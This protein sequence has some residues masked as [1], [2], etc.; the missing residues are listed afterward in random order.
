M[1]RALIIVLLTIVVSLAC[2]QYLDAQNEQQVY[3]FCNQWSSTNPL[4]PILNAAG[5]QFVVTDD[6]AKGRLSVSKQSQVPLLPDYSCIIHYNQQ[7]VV[8]LEVVKQPVF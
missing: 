1:N 6:K 8:S 5:N 7:R 4:Q 2:L 3:D